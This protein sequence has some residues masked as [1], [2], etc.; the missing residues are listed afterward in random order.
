MG[1]MMGWWRICLTLIRL[2][3]AAKANPA[4]TKPKI[5]NTSTQKI[6]L[7]VLI[8]L[9]LCLSVSLY[10]LL[11]KN[12]TP[13]QPENRTGVTLSYPACL[14]AYS[15]ITQIRRL[16]QQNFGTQLNKSSLLSLPSVF[17][18][19]PLVEPASFLKGC[20]C[21]CDGVLGNA[22]GGAWSRA[23][24][25]E[26]EA[27]APVAAAALSLCPRAAGSFHLLQ[28]KEGHSWHLFPPSRSLKCPSM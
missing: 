26:S 5:M 9:F 10:A 22:K 17:W 25:R 19:I 1:W 23:R 14:L 15:K 28:V 8:S 7:P 4:A 18:I 27:T 13:F 3:C 12:L 21:C 16:R 24:E 6:S 11:P 20:S 2:A